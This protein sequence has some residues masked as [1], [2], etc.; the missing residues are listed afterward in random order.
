VFSYDKNSKFCFRASASSRITHG[1]SMLYVLPQP[2]RERPKLKNLLIKINGYEKLP[3]VRCLPGSSIAAS[4]GGSSGKVV[5]TN[6]S[7]IPLISPLAK[8]RKSSGESRG[9]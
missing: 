3:I 9:R 7:P 1:C 8:R 6:E 5:G 4:L 2:S